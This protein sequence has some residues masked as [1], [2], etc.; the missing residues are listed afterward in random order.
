MAYKRKAFSKDLK[1]GGKWTHTYLFPMVLINLYT[2]TISKKIEFKG[3]YIF[4]QKKYNIQLK[5]VNWHQR[6][7]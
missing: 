7:V 6:M 5:K 4:C 3:L 1:V 2:R